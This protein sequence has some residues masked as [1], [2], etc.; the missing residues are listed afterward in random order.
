MGSVTFAKLAAIALAFSMA[1]AE[2]HRGRVIRQRR[3]KF[4][5]RSR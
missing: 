2:M 3:N 1:L 5:D 4:P